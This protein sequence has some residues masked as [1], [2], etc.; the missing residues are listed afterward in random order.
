MLLSDFD[1]QSMFLGNL[2]LKEHITK[3]EIDTKTDIL[4]DLRNCPDDIANILKE[5]IGDIPER[6]QYIETKIEVLKLRL[7]KIKELKKLLEDKSKNKL[8]RKIIKNI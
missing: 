6:C 2:S 1:Y 8:L 5:I 7:E 4:N 3:E